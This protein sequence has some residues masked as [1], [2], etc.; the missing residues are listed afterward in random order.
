MLTENYNDRDLLQ[1]EPLSPP[2]TLFWLNVASYNY[3]NKYKDKFT[4]FDVLKGGSAT[5]SGIPGP[6]PY[7]KLT[8]PLN[9]S[10]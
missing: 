9:H 8:E 3:F 2:S 5:Q 10:L 6:R 7:E 1:D 4:T